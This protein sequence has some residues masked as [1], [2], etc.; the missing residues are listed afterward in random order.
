MYGKVYCCCLHGIDGKL[1]ET[2]IDIGRGLPRL[3]IVGL[4]DSAVRESAE[5]GALRDSKQ[6]F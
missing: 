6:R 2:E 1:V 5:P 3:Q 4:P